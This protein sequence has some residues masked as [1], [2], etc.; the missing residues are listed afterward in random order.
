MNKF[1]FRRLVQLS[2]CHMITHSF[3]WR[4]TANG[5]ESES[6][7]MHRK[8]PSVLICFIFS[9]DFREI[10]K[11]FHVASAAIAHH[12]NDSTFGPQ[13]ESESRRHVLC[14]PACVQ[15][16]TKLCVMRHALVRSRAYAIKSKNT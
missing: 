2:L 16:P 5:I 8:L 15:W 9:N 4:Y 10:D 1:S 12:I 14:Q 11:Q 3:V 6:R 7:I 13:R